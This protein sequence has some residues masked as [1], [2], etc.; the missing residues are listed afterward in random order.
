ML[1]FQFQKSEPKKRHDENGLAL[2]ALSIVSH[3]SPHGGWPGRR[4]KRPV[5]ATRFIPA[6]LAN[7][8]STLSLSLRF[9]SL[10][11][12]KQAVAAVVS[13]VEPIYWKVLTL[14][15]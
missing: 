13:P 6:P 15:Y 14:L 3:D 9:F 2:Y 7:S 1:R 11:A 4:N 8:D 10:M 5:P 12:S